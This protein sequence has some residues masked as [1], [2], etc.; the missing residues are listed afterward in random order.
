VEPNGPRRGTLGELIAGSTLEPLIDCLSCDGAAFVDP[1]RD[2]STMFAHVE[3]GRVVFRLNG[4]SAVKHVF[5]IVP[6]TVV[7]E[8]TNNLGGNGSPSNEQRQVVRVNCH[9][10]NLSDSCIVR[11]KTIPNADSVAA[12][13]APRRIYVIVTRFSNATLMHDVLVSIRT[14]YNKEWAR[15][16][17]GNPQGFVMLQPPLGPLLLQAH[18]PQSTRAHPR[19]FGTAFVTV[20][21]EVDS[22]V[23][24]IGDPAVCEKTSHER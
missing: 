18:C 22:T 23:N 5:P 10:R 3:R 16:K 2:T 21:P 15:M 6:S 12:K 1:D 9:P 14:L 20:R 8:V 11:E 19:I 13:N 24:I 7:F 4:R 17:T